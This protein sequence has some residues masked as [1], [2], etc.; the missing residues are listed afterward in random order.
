MR[1]LPLTVAGLAHAEAGER[2]GVMDIAATQ[3]AFARIG[4]LSRIDL[5]LRPGA[6]IEIVRE[7]I[8]RMLPAGVAVAAP[9]DNARTTLRMSRA[10]RVNL[11]VL[12]LVA[13]FTGGLLVFSTQALSVVRRRAHFALLRTLGLTRGQLTKLLVLEGVLL[14]LA[15]SL[16]GLGAGYALAYVVLRVDRRRSRRRL[17]RGVAPQLVPDVAAAVVFAAVGIAAAALA[18]PLPARRRHARNPRRR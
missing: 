2:Y 9:A 7:R 12:A 4:T 13:L 3:D 18:S 15:G 10:Y 6:S 11:N 5:R 14:G 16:V 1:A 8:A 17:L